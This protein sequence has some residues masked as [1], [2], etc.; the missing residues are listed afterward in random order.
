MRNVVEKNKFIDIFYCISV[1]VYLLPVMTFLMI[2]AVDMSSQPWFIF[3]YFTQYI[4][5]I[6]KFICLYAFMW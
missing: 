2:L 3:N 6:Y 4:C 1:Q 5:Y